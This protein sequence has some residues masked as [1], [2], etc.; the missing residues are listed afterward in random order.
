VGIYATHVLPRILDLAMGTKPATAERARFLADVSGRVLEVGFGSGRNLPH[1][2]RAVT[3]VVAIDPSTGG[4]S[5]ARGRIAR[6]PFPVEFIPIAGEEIAAPDESFDSVVSTFTLCSIGD[7]AGALRQMSR[8]LKPGGR[9]FFVEHGR[10][11]DPDVRRWQ[12][13]LNGVQNFCFGCNLNRPI[14][15]L[16]AGAGFVIESLDKHYAPG[17]PRFGAYVF[18]GCAVRR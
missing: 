5:L 6:A 14:D 10:S 4:A 13:R 7:P 17:V 11:D 9:F 2:P 15:E 12:D 16:I 3:S 1:Y 8:V 18:G